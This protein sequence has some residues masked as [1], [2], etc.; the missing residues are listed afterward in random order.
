MFK[1]LAVPVCAAILAMSCIASAQRL[2]LDERS[3]VQEAVQKVVDTTRVPSASV[4]VARGGR[5]V[6]TE[7]FG[8][9]QLPRNVGVAHSSSA[10][11][12]MSE[13]TT[14]P[15]KARPGMAYPIGSISKQFTAVCI[16]LLQE[17]GKLRL[18]DPVAKWFPN[19]TRAHDVTIRNL[20]THTS[21]YS[22]YAPQDYTIPAWTK[23]TQPLAVVT[24]WATRP[25]DFEPG[26]KWQY[27]NTNF[28]IAAQIVEKASGQKYHDYLW[29]NVITPLKL[30]GVLDLDTDR[31]KLDTQGYE[32]HALGPMRRA[33]LEAPGWYYGDAQL[34]MPVATLLAWDESIVHRTLLKA[35]SYEQLETGYV[36]KDGTDSG[37]GL[38]VQVRYFTGGKKFI[39]HSGEVGGYVANNVVDLTD[40]IS[41][42]ALTN[43]EASSAAG[44]IT[45]AVRKVLLPNLQAPVRTKRSG[46]SASASVTT[47]AQDSANADAVRTVITSLQEGK[48]DRSRL[49]ADTNFY[50]NDETAEDYEASLAP[51]GS[52]QQVK[53]NQAELRGG[54]VFRNYTLAFEKGNASL[55]TYTEPDGKLEQFLIAPAP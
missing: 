34:A 55:T 51:L 12:Q 6:F 32:Q 37:Y 52:L 18:D 7:A 2:S 30:E 17:Q 44:Q 53:Q 43:Q 19:F 3:R 42:A 21:G 9:A 41:Y 1:P 39:L 46:E 15:V 31:D 50:F 10:D 20:L 23:P 45:T 11:L 24:Q 54:M 16:L 49:S 35:E 36:L 29:T 8:S 48:L 4:G 22:D 26:T 13:L 38:G 27:S 28:Q 5:V 47:A 33:A 40:D 14:K 25:L